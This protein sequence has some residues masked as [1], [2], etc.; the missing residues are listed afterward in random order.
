MTTKTRKSLSLPAT[1]SPPKPGDFPLGSP[2]SRAASRAM[3]E[4][5][6]QDSK[7]RDVVVRIIGSD[8]KVKHRDPDGED[9]ER[10]GAMVIT[11]RLVEPDHR[12]VEQIE[13]DLRTIKSGTKTTGRVC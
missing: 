13:Q 8:G 9:H 4:R 12:R 6:E 7:N 3:V 1:D 2:L 11:V 10:A 5:M